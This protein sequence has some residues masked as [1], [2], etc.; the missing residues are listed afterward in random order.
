MKL[1]PDKVS[2]Q[3]DTAVANNPSKDRLIRQYQADLDHDTLERLEN[4]QIPTLVTVGTFDLAAP[5]L[6]AREVAQRISGAELIIFEN[7][8]HLHN[9]E[10]P[11]EF[12][13]ATLDFLRRNSR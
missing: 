11:E 10:N 2:A 7:G 1:H 13:L 9:V 5:P 8:G 6:Y 12:N 3:I 4:I